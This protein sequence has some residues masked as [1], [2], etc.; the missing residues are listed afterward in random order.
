MQSAGGFL[1]SGD[2]GHTFAYGFPQSDTRIDTV[3]TYGN[4]RLRALPAAEREAAPPYDVAIDPSTGDVWVAG[5][6]TG[7]RRSSDKGE[8]W[9]RVVLPPDHLTEIDPQNE[10]DFVVGPRRGAIG[11]INHLGFSVLV[12]SEGNVWA[13][14][15]KIGRAACREGE[16]ITRGA[17][18]ANRQHESR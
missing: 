11:H 15:P 10:Y 12:D 18:A 4:N 7:I 5:W 16:E 14:T 6:S 13:G 3:I 8:T 1:S 2:G 17:W 9:E